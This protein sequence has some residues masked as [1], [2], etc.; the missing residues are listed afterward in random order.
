MRVGLDEL[1]RVPSRRAWLLKIECNMFVDR[2]RRVR[3]SP[4]GS[5][6]DN[7][8]KTESRCSGDPGP[9]LLFEGEQLAGRLN[10]AWPSL[11]VDQQSLLALYAEG[12]SLAELGDITGL[13]S[14]AL[15]ARLHRARVRLGK[16]ILALEQRP[17][18]AAASG[19]CK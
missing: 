11:T 16:L 5:L 6:D 12:Y 14:G 18:L 4:V 9:D 2:M 15:K 3:R 13:P 10:E 19:E 1:E 7:L 17:R 8:G